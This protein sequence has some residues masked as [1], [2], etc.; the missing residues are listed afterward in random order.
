VGKGIQGAVLK[1]LG[2]RE[3]VLTVMGREYRADHFVRVFLRSDTLLAPGGE[4]PGNWVRA[5]F[6]DPGGGAKQFQRG[7][8]LVEADPGTGEFA[9]DFVIHHP[10]G[11]AAY[12]A[13]TCEPG[14]Q[15]VAMRFGEEPLEL[16]DPAPAGYLF[17]GDLASYPAIHALASSIP[18]EHPVVVYLE[19]HDERDVQLPLPSGPNIE[20][21][22]VDELPDGQGLAQAISGRDWTGWYA[23]VTAESLATRRARTPLEREFGLN[24]ATLHAHAYWVRGRAMG[25]SRVLEQAA[26]E[27]EPQPTVAPTAAPVPV[28]VLAP[29][30]GALFVG[31]LAQAL[32]AVVQIVPFILFAEVARLFLRG[33]GVDEFIAVGVAALLVMALSAAGTTVLLFGMHIYDA[34]FAAALRRRLMDKLSTLPLGWFTNRKAADVKT[35][36][37]DDVAALHYVVTHSVLDLVAA[38]VTPV[39]TLGYLFAVQWRLALVLLLPLVV[40]LFV[41]I[42]ISRRDADKNALVQRTSALASGQAQTFLSTIDQARV[43]GPRAVVDLPETLNRMGDVVERWQQETSLAKTQAVMINRPTT[44]LGLLVLAGWAFVSAGWMRPEELIVFLIVG[45]SC[46]AQLIG[47]ASGIGVLTQA[48]AARDSLE[49]LLGTPGLVSPDNRHAPPGH[50]RFA[51]VRFGYG[52][53]PAVL[54]ALDL[55]LEPGQ[56]TA[57]VGPSGAGKSTVAALLARMWDP[58]E[59]VVSI[60]GIDIRNLSSDELYA[61]VAILLQDVQLL[62]ASVRD[63]IALSRPEA[64]DEQVRAAAEAA[65]IH[66]R[67][68]QLPQGYDTVVDNTRLS[69]GERQRIGIARTLLADTPI[70]VLDEATAAADPDSEWAIRQGLDRLLTGRTV[71]MIAHRLHTVRDADRIVVLRDGVIAESG[72]HQELLDRNGTYAEL[73]HAGSGHEGSR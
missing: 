72:T 29:A 59:G 52:A 14:D 6:P 2:A 30:R 70:V 53:G 23:W 68:M 35:L 33:A 37:G 21:R 44:V 63:N 5:W 3:H 16:L 71:L 26:R 45:T 66:E 61:K 69:G 9:I 32:L 48:F 25:K 60:D 54:P 50:V 17:L 22:W 13:T 7:Y 65:Q 1:G 38:V 19:Q 51:G 24:R 62:R 47:I 8:T 42:R 64:T 55:E 12:W 58:Q 4:A 49:W 18:Q 41:M 39:V 27:Q 15:I 28:R 67:I 20:A 11:P 46:G 73:W 36:V 40:F 34:R 31:G 10:I 56:V 57:L 43:F